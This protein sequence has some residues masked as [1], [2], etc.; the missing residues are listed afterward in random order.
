MKITIALW[1]MVWAMAG[2]AGAEEIIAA[3]F[4]SPD[5]ATATVPA[6]DS[7]A[8]LPLSAP[9]EIKIQ[10][11]ETRITLATEEMSGW[12]PPFLIIQTGV[13]K[14]NPQYPAWASLIWNLE[15]LKLTSGAYELSWKLIPL[16]EKFHGASA[17]VSLVSS[18]GKPVTGK[19]PPDRAPL[20][21][22]FTDKGY[23]RAADR[24]AGGEPV[25]YEPDMPCE[26]VMTF[27]LDAKTWSVFVNGAA[28]VDNLA[29][30]ADLAVADGLVIQSV[31]IT[32]TG[33]QETG[34][35]LADVRLVKK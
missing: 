31:A 30:P 19:L 9:T 32:G 6:P 18:Q 4:A 21:V 29:F 26:F 33:V 12:K 28:L 17:T 2:S 25:Q 5:A 11:G 8:A 20:R 3:K 24:D 23:I 1:A 34:V 13:L 27:D 14:A 15:K 35:A 16:S 22:T 10:S 7:A